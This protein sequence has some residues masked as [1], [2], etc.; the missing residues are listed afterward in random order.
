MWPFLAITSSL[1]L[2]GAFFYWRQ[3]FLRQQAL[4]ASA[5]EKVLSLKDWQKKHSENTE[6]RQL[7]LFNNMVEGILLLD[8]ER[9]IELM[10]PNLERLLHVGG[11]IVGKGVLEVIRLPEFS[12]L[13]ERVEADGDVSGFEL[14]FPEGG[15][16]RFFE[17]NAVSIRAKDTSGHSTLLVFH[18]LTGQ[19]R[20]E[21]TRRD[22]VANVSHELRTPLAM[23]KGY[24]ETLLD[25]AKDDATVRDKFLGTI[26]K[27]ANRLSLLIEDLLSLS[28]LE[29]GKA[30]LKLK[31][32]PLRKVAIQVIDELAEKAA[33][34]NIEFHNELSE[35][36]TVIADQARLR[37]VF[38][39]LIDNAIKYGKPGGAIEISSESI[40]NNHVEISIHNDGAAIPRDAQDRIFER[41]Y[42]VDSARSREQGGTGLGLAIVKHIV[43]FHGGEVR[44]ESKPGQGTTFFF[45]LKPEG[46]TPLPTAH[47]EKKASAN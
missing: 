7:A 24:V 47:V 2:I 43:Q 10:N 41:F 33:A 45:T 35:A 3:V 29:D 19:K 11:H 46:S 13:L 25:G 16:V 27:H 44:V 14:E 22:F 21:N 17:I 36:A 15:V 31:K 5:E 30:I 9:R 38:F 20:L 42:R 8:S 1:L 26:D 4:I 12:E 37:Q 28:E 18:D 39:N 23:I 32:I 34:K 6:Q 40:T